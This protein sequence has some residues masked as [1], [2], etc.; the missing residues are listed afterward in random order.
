MRGVV[1][2]EFVDV[3]TMLV[4]FVAARTGVRVGTRLPKTLSA[5]FVRLWRTGGPALNRVLDRPQVTFECWAGSSVRA[6]E[7]AADV[8]RALL[9]DLG[10]L[11][12]VRGVE[13]MT[14]LH[15]DPDPDREVERYSFTFIFR[16]RGTRSG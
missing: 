16:V 14:G 1:M 7:L 10:G 15:Y 5:E 3:E 12:L 2:V 13:E 9:N 6:A 8:R 11:P 4:Q